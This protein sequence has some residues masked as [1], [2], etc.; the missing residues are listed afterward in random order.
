MRREKSMLTSSK[1]EMTYQDSY[2]EFGFIV[3]MDN[4][5]AKCV[6]CSENLGKYDTLTPDY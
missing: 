5:R 4:I 6:I 2:T 1:R 3:A